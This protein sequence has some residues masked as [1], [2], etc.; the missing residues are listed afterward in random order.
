[1]DQALT[2]FG[3]AATVHGEV[4]HR[5]GGPADDDV[6][7]SLEHVSGVRSHIW[8]SS[9]AAAKGPRMRVLGSAG[10][11]VVDELDGQEDALKAGMRPEP[12]EWGVEPEERWGRLVRGDEERRV[13]SA[14]GDWP[15]F[16]RRLEAAL[17]GDGEVPVDPRDAVAVAEIL[18]RA[19]GE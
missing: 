9:V 18:E 16:Y 6:F 11:F 8:A 13:P 19:A 3:P 5:R 15:A 7:L 10:A 17:R 14:D 4:E 1:M 12:G 2:L